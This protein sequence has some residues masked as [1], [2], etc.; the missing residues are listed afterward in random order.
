VERSGPELVIG[1]S[2]WYPKMAKRSRQSHSSAFKEK[3]A[4]T[5]PKSDTT[6]AELTQ[7]YDVHPNQITHWKKQLQE[8]VSEGSRRASCPRVNLKWTSRCSTRRLA[9]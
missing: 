9:S 3:V 1:T 6:L 8:R 5:V 7:Q 4:L 2:K